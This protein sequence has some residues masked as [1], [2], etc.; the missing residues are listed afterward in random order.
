MNLVDLLVCCMTLPLN[1]CSTVKLAYVLLD[2]CVSDLS[3][4]L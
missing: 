1:L 3:S 2:Y 4:G